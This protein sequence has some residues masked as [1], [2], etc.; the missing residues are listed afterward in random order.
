MKV[1]D[2]I[3]RYMALEVLLGAIVALKYPETIG[4]CPPRVIPWLLGA[5][6]FGMGLTL[7]GRD[8]ALVLARPRDV[9]L[10]VGA[11]FI[12]MSGLAWLVA[13]ALGLPDE[14]ALGIVLVGTC[15]GG[16][17]SNVIAYLARGDVALSVTM[18]SC[19]TVLAPFLTPLLT[20]GLAGHSVDVDAAAMLISIAKVVLLPVAVGVF[21]NECFGSFARRI[22]GAMPAFSSIAIV[23]IVMVVMAASATRIL[24]NLGIILV[25]VILH[26]VLGLACGY[27]VGRLCGMDASRCRT[28]AIEVGMQ[29]SGLAVSLAH[30]HFAAYP[31]ATV[32]GALFSVWHNLSGSLFAALCRRLDERKTNVSAG[33]AH[34]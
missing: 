32:P 20:L 16:T 17:A 21:V 34:H 2:F 11:Q 7:R 23:V 29:N 14:I 1:S 25:A 6:M 3:S 10:G 8:F 15:P 33:S 30:T 27:G 22:R 26:N 13:K 19:S 18:T 4:T 31:L 28:V 12:L 24:D 5:V 9:L